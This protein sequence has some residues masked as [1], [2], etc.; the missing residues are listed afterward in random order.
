MRTRRL[1]STSLHVSEIGFGCWGLGGDAYGKVT[2]EASIDAVRFAIDSGI[3]FFDTSDIY[4]SDSRSE[5]VLGQALK[6]G[7]RERAILATKGGGIE[8]LVRTDYTG[9]HLREALEAS[10]KRLGT[11]SVDLYQLHNPRIDDADL[12]HRAFETLEALRKEGKVRAIGL[13][14][15]SPA[16]ALFAVQNLPFSTVQVNFNLMDQRA[17][18]LGLFESAQSKG[19]G[20][21]IRTP[22]CFGFLSGRYGTKGF[23][24]SD[25]RSRWSEEQRKLWAEGTEKFLEFKGSETAAQLA[26]RFCLSFEATATVIPGMLSRDHVRENA[27]ASGLPHFSK[28]EIDTAFDIYRRYRF[29]VGN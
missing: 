21:I 28:A 20:L 22:L 8:G 25:H 7:Y 4:G 6:N 26:L 11:D 3:T 27:A 14:V 13:S 9:T 18:A 5:R 2:D 15:K 16:E 12:C 29:F 10:L 1:G 23:D 17:R 19:V 24:E